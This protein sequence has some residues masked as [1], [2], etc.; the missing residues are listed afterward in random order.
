MKKK[1]K[2]ILCG[3]M[4]LIMAFVMAM[5]VSVSAADRTVS[6]ASE[7]TQAITEAEN[8][9]TITLGDNI[10]QDIT[11]PADKNI[12]L[13]LNGKI[14]TGKVVVEG[15][16][17]VKDNTVAGSPVVSNDYKTVTYE[18]GKITNAGTTV[19]VM[20]GTFI[21]ESGKIESTGN[22]GV[23][24]E[25]ATTHEGNQ[26]DATATIN[27]GYIEAREFG[28]GVYGNK[29][30][31]NIEGGVIVGNDNAAVAGNGSNDNT[32]TYAGTEINVNGG[33]LIGHIITDGYIAC[34]IYH[35]QDGILNVNGGTVYADNGVGILMRGGELNM[36]GGN[37]IATGTS[38]GKVGDST[39]IQ[40]CYGIQIDCESGYY[41]ATNSKGVIN[42]GNVQAADGV[43]TLSVVAGTQVPADGK[44]VVQNGAFS[45]DVS[46]YVEEGKIAIKYTSSNDEK[47]YHVG[48]PEQINDIVKNAAKG[49]KIEVLKGDIALSIPVG[50]VEVSNTG[51][52]DVTVNDEAVTKG[53]PV[54]TTEPA[55]QPTIPSQPET[56]GETEAAGNSAKTGDD[57]NMT[58]VI[59]LMGI[60]AATAAGTVVYGRRKRSN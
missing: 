60:A 31:A 15:G 44:M 24:V 46:Q 38:S 53:T 22:L 33:M 12:T 14:L 32:K 41:D 49:D 47:T 4:T 43:S 19:L 18:S 34:G 45:S 17:T 3:I 27:N 9:D 30:T 51:D 42:G 11:I 20:G 50:G 57:F 13:N 48:T 25:G 23:Y 40:N 10:T 58:A 59:A 54:V 39:T 29:A 8:G 36:T 26:I 1:S 21:L 16:L 6:D 7:L 56:A 35:P 28:V 5:P 52:G 55:Q 37:V 2:I